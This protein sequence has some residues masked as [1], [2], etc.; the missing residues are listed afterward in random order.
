[1]LKVGWVA[2]SLPA[3]EAD[4]E[5]RADAVGEDQRG[6]LERSDDACPQVELLL[7]L[8]PRRGCRAATGATRRSS[9][10]L[11]VTQQGN[12]VLGGPLEEVGE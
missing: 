5:Q 12:Y 6:Y 7:V 4:D 3:A 1:M 11:P 2:A 10:E 9:K 8:K